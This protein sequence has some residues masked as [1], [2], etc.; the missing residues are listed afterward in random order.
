M[1]AG[2]GVW[3][4]PSFLKIETLKMQRQDWIPS[5]FVS[6]VSFL[7]VHSTPALQYL[8]SVPVNHVAHVPHFAHNTYQPY[9]PFGERT[10]APVQG[11]YTSTPFGVNTPQYFPNY[12]IHPRVLGSSVS[13]IQLIPSTSI[14]PTALRSESF[15]RP[16]QLSVPVYTR[17]L[18]SSV[19]QIQLV[20]RVSTQT[21]SSRPEGLTQPKV[22][23]P[24]QQ[25]VPSQSSVPQEQQA[26]SHQPEPNIQQESA[27]KLESIPQLQLGQAPET[28]K[29]PFPSSPP[30]FN[31]KIE[32][33]RMELAC[34]P[35]PIFD[36]KGTP[37]DAR[38]FPPRRKSCQPDS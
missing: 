8:P 24:S 14:Q 21:S 5:T 13:Q 1:R 18:E 33:L 20:S 26:P 31:K 16:S 32:R 23:A 29:L 22:S 28:N 37:P 10:H 7:P 2:S 38:V 19:S 11:Y 6:G 27:P 30:P 9:N 3:S 15:S 34:T 12:D 36:S 4:E 25:K 17:V 35:P